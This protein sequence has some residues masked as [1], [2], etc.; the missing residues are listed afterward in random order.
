[1][2]VVVFVSCNSVTHE[3]E[4]MR[5]LMRQPVKDTLKYGQ[6]HNA[7]LGLYLDSLLCIQDTTLSTYL[8]DISSETKK[9][10][11]SHY[12]YDCSSLTGSCTNF[13]SIESIQIFINNSDSVLSSDRDYMGQ[14]Y[15]S[16]KLRMYSFEKNTN[17]TVSHLCDS[18]AS[19]RNEL[20]FA[21]PDSLRTAYYV[22]CDVS[23]QILVYSTKYWVDQENLDAWADVAEKA[24]AKRKDDDSSKK[25]EDTDKK[26][27]EELKKE[28]VNKVIELVVADVDGAVK[29]W[30]ISRTPQGAAALGSIYSGLAALAWD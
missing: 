29:G 13:P 8:T 2:F 3:E 5:P 28:V 21:I 10:M 15:R 7:L 17:M 19:L 1:M 24:R 26:D 9:Y 12:N 6:D 25:D 16:I 22:A 20:L 27:K 23:T 14:F 11:L 18:V 30:K 4:L